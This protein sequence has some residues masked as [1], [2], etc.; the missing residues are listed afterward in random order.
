M[1]KN[2]TIHNVNNFTLDM[3]IGKEVEYLI[4]NTICKAPLN[5]HDEDVLYTTKFL[6]SL[7]FSGMLNHILWLKVGASVVLLNNL[8]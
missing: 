6:N 8:N 5:I 7:R 4:Y 3:L 1:A 2:E